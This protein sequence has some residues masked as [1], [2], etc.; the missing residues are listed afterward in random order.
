MKIQKTTSNNIK[1]IQISN[2]IIKHHSRYGVLCRLFC[3]HCSITYLRGLDKCWSKYWISMDIHGYQWISMDIYGYPWIS[4][5]IHG[6]IWI[7]MD[8]YGYPWITCTLG[9]VPTWRHRPAPNEG[10]PSAAPHPSGARA[11]GAR[12]GRISGWYPTKKKLPPLG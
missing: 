11:F 7:S 3:G 9:V 6:Y 2:K 5:D 1:D 4:M 8:I 12:P 10:R